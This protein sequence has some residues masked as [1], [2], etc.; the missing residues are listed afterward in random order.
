M[1]WA[2]LLLTFSL[3]V[4]PGAKAQVHLVVVSGLSGEAK[5][6]ESFHEWATGLCDAATRRWGVPESNIVYLAEK[7]ERDPRRIAGRSTWENVQ[8]AVRAVADRAGTQD[9][10][11]IVVI[12]HGTVQD[13]QAKLSL[14]GPDPTMQDVAGL[15]DAFPT[16]PLVFVNTASA[17]GDFIGALSAEG[18]AVVTAT[19][20]GRE[21]NETIFGRFFIEAY[22]ADVADAD[23]DGR[24]SVLEAFNYARGET[25]RLY[26]SENRLLTE[27]P[28][29]DDNGD[30]EGSEEPGSEALDGR[31]AARLFLSG[32]VDPRVATGEIA[33]PKLAALYAE[34]RALEDAVAELRLRKDE[35]AT[36]AYE[37]ELERLLLE[38]ALKT[39]EIREL[40]EKGQ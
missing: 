14:P 21:R 19:R 15:L 39:R 26:E 25:A 34:R 33:D 27:H 12:G 23:K 10:V 38:L 8:S 3:T 30:G 20:S 4:V 18:R 1:R 40:E 24:V 22:A 5:Y 6:A 9:L 37:T 32:A 11:F 31:F 13:D 28:L 29:L 2:G 16:Q 7:V 35:M 36:E 17:S